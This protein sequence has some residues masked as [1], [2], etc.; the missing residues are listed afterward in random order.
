M[1]SYDLP[2][3]RFENRNNGSRVSLSWS[4]RRSLGSSKLWEGWTTISKETTQLE[5]ENTHSQ[6]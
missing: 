4:P 2:N 1:L 5:E 3:L 6:K